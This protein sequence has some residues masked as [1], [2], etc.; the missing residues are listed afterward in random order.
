MMYLAS[1]VEHLH[2]SLV[3]ENGECAYVQEQTVTDLFNFSMM[4]EEVGH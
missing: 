2:R 1:V 3:N 4:L